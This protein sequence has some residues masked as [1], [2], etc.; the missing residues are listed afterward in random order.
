MGSILVVADGESGESILVVVR[1]TVREGSA[2]VVIRE[3]GSI[4]V[5]DGAILAISPVGYTVGTI[6]VACAISPVGFIIGIIPVDNDKVRISEAISI[7]VGKG[8]FFVVRDDEAAV[9]SKRET[10]SISE[11]EVREGA[12][13]AAIFPPGSV[14]TLS[15][16]ERETSSITEG[17]VCRST[18][19]ISEEKERG[20]A[21]HRSIV[22]VGTAVVG[23]SVRNEND[24][25]SAIISEDEVREATIVSDEDGVC[26]DDSTAIISEDEVREADEDGVCDDDST[27]IISEDEVREAMIVS[28]ISSATAERILLSLEDPSHQDDS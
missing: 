6:S 28:E 23:K 9:V 20:S 14:V 17:R 2:T 15:C 21:V 13:N 24:A 8:S 18:V 10:V 1:G 25:G 19:S 11:D 3:I 22:S 4:L 5:D 27:A 26:D 7:A 12:E 16:V